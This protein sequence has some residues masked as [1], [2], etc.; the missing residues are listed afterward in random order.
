MQAFLEDLVAY[1]Q[2]RLV[3]L[4]LDGFEHCAVELQN[5]LLYR[6][7]EP[8]CFDLTQR[9]RQ[10]VIVIAGREIPQFEQ[11]WPLTECKAIIRSVR[12]LGKWTTAHVEECFQAH[13]Y[14]DFTPQDVT[15]FH[16]FLS[17]GIPPLEVIQLIPY[18]VANRRNR[19]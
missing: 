9:P 18:F 8:Y 19:S 10:L 17:N 12:A 14:P 5:W 15:A 11:H 1:C 6:F 2:E 7:L 3:V 13:D 4:L 16:Q